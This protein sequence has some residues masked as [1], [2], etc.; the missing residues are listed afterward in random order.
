MKPDRALWI[1]LGVIVLLVA[2]A[3]TLFFV[4]DGGQAYGTESSPE[5]VVRNYVLALH[6]GDFQRAYDYLQDAEGRP[7]YAQFRETFLNAGS[8]IEDTGVQ[9]LSTERSGD[10]ATVHLSVIRGGTGPFE[11]SWS[12]NNEA[13]LTLQQGEWKLAYFPYPYWGWDW[14]QVEKGSS[15]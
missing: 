5:G 11:R 7:T 8:N 9:I 6:D 15:P 2:L 1:F 10:D 12:E 3:L 13:W 14:Y 4:R